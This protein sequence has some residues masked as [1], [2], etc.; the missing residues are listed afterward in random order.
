[1]KSVGVIS[2]ICYIVGELY[3]QIFKTNKTIYKLI[4]II[5]LIVGGILGIVIYK[6]N[7]EVIF[8][9]P[10]IWDAIYIGILSGAS[11]TGVNQVI[12]Q[13]LKGKEEENE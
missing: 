10:N 1:M 12:K 5:E 7:K 8:N 6:T 2:V 4:P 3:K 13:L 11:S 9:V